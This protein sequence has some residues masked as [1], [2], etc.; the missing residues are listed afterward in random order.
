MPY[1]NE[2][3]KNILPNNEVHWKPQYCPNCNT[4]QNEYCISIELKDRKR[5][6][7]CLTFPNLLKLT[8][9]VPI[10]H[11]CYYEHIRAIDNVK[12]YIDFEYHK[13][14]LHTMIDTRKAL[15]TIRKIFINNIRTL[16][17]NEN[18]LVEDM[19][20]LEPSNANKE[21][22]HM[23]L[24]NSNVRILNKSYLYSFITE[25][26]RT[27]LLSTIRQQCLK[28]NKS[29]NYDH[30]DTSSLFD[31]INTLKHVWLEWFSCYECKINDFDLYVNDIA[32]LLAFDHSGSFVSSIDF[33]V[34][35][36]EQDFRIFM[37]TK[38]TEIRPLI[39]STLFA[40]NLFTNTLIGRQ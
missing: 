12:F 6:Y 15:L 1:K 29:I 18:I 11:R 37:C 17:N 20:L 14:E 10:Q 21:S 30:I 25:T 33:K 34:Y 5:Q 9:T 24:A 28:I 40:E 19:I 8:Q 36:Q 16:C 31:I 22:F 26:I 38:S 3:I 23:I 27:I 7:T 35:N 13:N 32:H 4:I 2:I 39:K